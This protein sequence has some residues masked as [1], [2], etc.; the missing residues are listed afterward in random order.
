MSGRARRG[1]AASAEMELE[2]ADELRG[3]V[4]VVEVVIFWSV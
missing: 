2:Q 1:A 4:E 3:L